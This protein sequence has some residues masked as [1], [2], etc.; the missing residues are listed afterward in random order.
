MER[1]QYLQHPLVE[2]VVYEIT[3]SKVEIACPHTIFLCARRAT[4]IPLSEAVEK[5]EK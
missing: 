5:F 2:G 3:D 4:E 1:N